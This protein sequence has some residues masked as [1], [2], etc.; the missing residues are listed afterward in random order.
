VCVYVCLCVC[1]HFTILENTKIVNQ[2]KFREVRKF[3]RSSFAKMLLRL[4][5]RLRISVRIRVRVRVRGYR[6]GLGL[7]LR[8]EVRVKG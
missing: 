5:I 6:L 7:R 4:G 1:T 8:L 2:L 3:C